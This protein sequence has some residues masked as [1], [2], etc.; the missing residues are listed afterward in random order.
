MHNYRTLHSKR[1]NS[2]SGIE[3]STFELGANDDHS[4]PSDSLGELQPTFIEG[5][6]DP[7][8][9]S[10]GESEEDDDNSENLVDLTNVNLEE[11]IISDAVSNFEP[12][13]PNKSVLSLYQGEDE[14]DAGSDHQSRSTTTVYRYYKH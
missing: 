8:N 12:S 13:V 2:E 1:N 6:H 5:I 11:N 10:D 7:N 9:E 14:T 4:S 3:Y